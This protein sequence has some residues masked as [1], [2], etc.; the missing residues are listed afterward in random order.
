MEE[1]E[2]L[3]SLGN[4]SHN[5]SKVR[6]EQAYWQDN[7]L[8]EWIMQSFLAPLILPVHYN[9]YPSK[10]NFTHPNDGWTGL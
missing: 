1:L 7:L 9:F 10:M 3:P 5:Q 6:K 2:L 8:T 4:P